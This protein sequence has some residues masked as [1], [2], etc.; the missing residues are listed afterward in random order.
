MGR[1]DK[2][3][4]FC[5]CHRLANYNNISRVRANPRTPWSDLI[6]LDT[7]SKEI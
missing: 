3:A 6:G 5:F 7:N 1:G 2:I 4:G